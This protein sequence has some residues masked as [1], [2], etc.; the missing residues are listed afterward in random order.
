MTVQHPLR[1]RPRPRCAGGHAVQEAPR[2]SRELHPAGGVIS[3]PQTEPATALRRYHLLSTFD[4]FQSLRVCGPG[5]VLPRRV[6]GRQRE[7]GGR[8]SPHI[9]VSPG[10]MVAPYT[11]P[12]G[13]GSA[14]GA[15]L[16][17]L[18][19]PVEESLSQAC[20]DSLT[21]AQ[22]FGTEPWVP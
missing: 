12:S 8:C 21:S 14:A 16:Y 9:A 13:S 11:L 20:E 5:L 3:Y 17:S 22:V 18:L 6:R 15:S 1:V 19:S 7:G 2:P 4:T 10:V